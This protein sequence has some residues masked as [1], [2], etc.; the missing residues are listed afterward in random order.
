MLHVDC[1]EAVAS[2]ST[3][4]PHDNKADHVPDLICVALLDGSHIALTVPLLH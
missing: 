4:E 1:S 2:I 3:A